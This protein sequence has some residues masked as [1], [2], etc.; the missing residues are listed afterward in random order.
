MVY[1]AGCYV[2]SLTKEIFYDI[3]PTDYEHRVDYALC[4]NGD[5]LWK[6]T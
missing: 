3:I 1:T 5:V 4:D 6:N 2:A